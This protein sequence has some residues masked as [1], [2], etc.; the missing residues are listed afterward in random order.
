MKIQ[1]ILANI[2]EIATSNGLFALTAALICAIRSRAKPAKLFVK[3][4]QLTLAKL[5]ALS[6]MVGEIPGVPLAPASSSKRK[7]GGDRPRSEQR[8]RPPLPHRAVLPVQPWA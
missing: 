4:G 3:L 2:P 1:S 8:V 5:V 6:Q 7:S